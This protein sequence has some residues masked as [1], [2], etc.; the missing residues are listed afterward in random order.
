MGDFEKVIDFSNLYKAWKKSKCGKR[1]SNQLCKIET[2]T[3]D[4]LLILQK[5]LIDKTYEIYPYNEFEI[6]EPKRRIIKSAHPKDKIVQMC[7][8]K[9]VL[10]PTMETHFVDRCFAGRE[11]KGTLYGL[12]TLLQD[13]K[14]FYKENGNKGYF[15]KCD[16]TKFFYTIDHTILKNEIY[17]YFSDKDII[18]LCDKFIDSV[19]DKGLALGN[20]TS[21]V[22]A[23]LLLNRLDHYII[24]ELGIKY[25]GRYIDDFYLI[26]SDKDYLMECLNKIN[27]VIQSL[28]LTLNGKTQII[29]FEQGIK[30]LGFHT[31][32]NNGKPIRK[33]CN[34]N[35]RRA[36]KRYSRLLRK[37][38]SGKIAQSEYDKS[39]NS[40]LAF[41]NL[42]ILKEVK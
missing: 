13:V 21:Q 36:N 24:E 10:I 3:F 15:L 23:N 19:E 29:P 9:N 33:L 16:I 37:V 32:P 40:W 28:K 38:R 2:M 30:F 25:Y 20:Q 34:A 11:N 39:Y 17:R 31:Y 5:Q 42:E 14:D 12:N 18:W 4:S 8:C 7:L 26:H 27:S 22:F 35:R 1:K 6:Y 41:K